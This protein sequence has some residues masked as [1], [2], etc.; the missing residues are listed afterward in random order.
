MDPIP[1][2]ES[3]GDSKLV[4]KTVQR[5]IFSGSIEVF[6]L[7]D[8]LELYLERFKILLSLNHIENDKEKVYTFI[9]FA[10]AEVL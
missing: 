6:Q 1:K 9:T 5:P 10:G 8:D 4:S 3:N 7:E 2:K